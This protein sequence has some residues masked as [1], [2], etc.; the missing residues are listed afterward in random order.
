MADITNN[1]NQN[2]ETKSQERAIKE[3]V[4]KGMEIYILMLHNGKVFINH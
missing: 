3:N 1:Q 4:L 2:K